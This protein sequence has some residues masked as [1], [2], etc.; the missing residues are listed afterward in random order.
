MGLDVCVCEVH[1]VI[2]PCCTALSDSLASLGAAAG[3]FTDCRRARQC[4]RL[5]ASTETNES[6]HWC[7]FMGPGQ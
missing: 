5:F 6:S 3:E 2:I 4:S 1:A 7:G